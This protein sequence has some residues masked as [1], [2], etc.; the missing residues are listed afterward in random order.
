MFTAKAAFTAHVKVTIKTVSK[1]CS[2]TAWFCTKKVFLLWT[3]KILRFL[4]LPPASEGWGKVIFPVCSQPGGGYPIHSQQGVPH[5][6]PMGGTP[7]QSQQSVPQQ[8]QYGEPPRPPCQDWMEYP[9]R[10]G[11]GY[12]PRGK[13]SGVSTCYAAGGMLLAFTQEVFLVIIISCT[14]KA[15]LHIIVKVLLLFAEWLFTISFAIRGTNHA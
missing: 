14:Y 5:P 15:I 2:D 4:L 13:S 10:I 11:C 8:G 9:C 6:S 1:S 3:D 12:S 7:I